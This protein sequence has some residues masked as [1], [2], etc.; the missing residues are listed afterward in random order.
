MPLGRESGAV[1]RDGDPHHFQGRDYFLC[2]YYRVPI[3]RN[4]ISF[5]IQLDSQT[6]ITFSNNVLLPGLLFFPSKTESTKKRKCYSIRFFVCLHCEFY[7]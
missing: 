5:Y 2:D 7:R 4:V 6:I 3:V 1:T